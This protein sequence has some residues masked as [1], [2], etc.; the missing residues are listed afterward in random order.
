[1]TH[2]Y[3]AV[4]QTAS[5]YREGGCKRAV[6]SKLLTFRATASLGTAVG[7][8]MGSG[9][10]GQRKDGRWLGSKSMSLDD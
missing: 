10:C 5:V 8:N 7:G 9:Y 2:L 4:Y 6:I 1:M 3:I